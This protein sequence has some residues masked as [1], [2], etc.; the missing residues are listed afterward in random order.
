MSDKSKRRVTF[1][2]FVTL[3]QLVSFV[4]FVPLSG[5]VVFVSLVPFVPFVLLAGTVA[6]HHAVRPLAQ[7]AAA[8][9][10]MCGI[11]IALRS[12]C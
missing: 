5:R 4:P 11:S 9:L 12:K 2:P 6:L 1:V 8:P 10:P 7:A 3:V